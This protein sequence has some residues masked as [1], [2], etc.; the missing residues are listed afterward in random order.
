MGR[1]KAK[2]RVAVLIHSQLSSKINALSL[3]GRSAVNLR[4]KLRDRR[5]KYFERIRTNAEPLLDTMVRLS[6]KSGISKHKRYE[7]TAA[8]V[9]LPDPNR[10][11]RIPNHLTWPLY[12]ARNAP[13]A[14]KTTKKTWLSSRWFCLALAADHTQT[15][16]HLQPKA[17]IFLPTLWPPSKGAGAAMRMAPPLCGGWRTSPLP[18]GKASL[19]PR[20]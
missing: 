18:T 7:A 5:S 2:C 19:L 9:A 11:V 4:R 16:M 3:T 13:V 1:V 14:T 15:G 8:P 6:L 10:T 17:Q 20:T 12:L